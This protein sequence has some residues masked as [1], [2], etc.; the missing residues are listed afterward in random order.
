MTHHW[1]IFNMVPTGIPKFY[2]AELFL[3]RWCWRILVHE[4]VPSQVQEFD[5]PVV[6]LIT[7]PVRSHWK[8]RCWN[9]AIDL[10]FLLPPDFSLEAVTVW[11]QRQQG[12]KQHMF[13]LTY[14]KGN[15][16]ITMEM[17]LFFSTIPKSVTIC[18]SFELQ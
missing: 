8:R 11:I 4:A 1:L 16:R 5:L 18:L 17:E 14:W 15:R 2:S 6:E 9:A 12:L 13:L 10:N 7:S 3:S